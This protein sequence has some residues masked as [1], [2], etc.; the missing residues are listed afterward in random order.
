MHRR[1]AVASSGCS[2][3]VPMPLRPAP[4]GMRVV[5]GRCGILPLMSVTMDWPRRAIEQAREIAGRSIPPA[6]SA[7]KPLRLAR[8]IALADV[9]AGRVPR[10]GF[11]MRHYARLLL[12]SL[13]G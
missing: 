9:R 13:R 6:G 11:S 10:G 7:L 12:A 4:S 5:S 2:Q 3:R 1:G 8:A